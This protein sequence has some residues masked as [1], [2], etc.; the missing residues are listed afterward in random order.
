MGTDVHVI[1]VVP[2]DRGEALCAQAFDRLEQLEARWSRFRP[3][4][5]LCRLNAAN[6]A[7]VVVAPITFDLLRHAVASWRRT[8]GAYDP[9]VAPSVVAA[10]YDR[11]FAKV[12]SDGPALDAPVVGP[13][14]GC[15]EIV[16]DPIVRSV[17]LPHDVTLDLGGVAKGFAADVV[18]DELH[19]AGALGVCVNLGGDLRVLGTPPRPDAAAEGWIVEVEEAD[20]RPLLALTD[21]AVATTSRRRRTWQRGD[22]TYHHVID[23]R[24]GAPADVRW[25]AATVIAGR[26]RDAEALAKAA[27]LSPDTATASAVLQRNDATGLLVDGDGRSVPLEGIDAFRR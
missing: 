26:A 13:A 24:T 14:P 23:P 6:G 25:L 27:F 20:D 21:G 2:D 10:G 18:A 7:P 5:E 11:D 8:D 4:S 15:S 3:T 9:T 12:P 17:R 22:R 1:V 16:L 19:A